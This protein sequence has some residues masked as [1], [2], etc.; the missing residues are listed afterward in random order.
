MS[1]VEKRQQSSE[2][3]SNCRAAHPQKQFIHRESPQVEGLCQC[4]LEMPPHR[5]SLTPLVPVSQRSKGRLEISHLI[6]AVIEQG[7]LGFLAVGTLSDQHIARVVQ[8]IQAATPAAS[9]P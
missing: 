3:V 1:N 7:D 6:K 4:D 2:P 8:T 9:R 5:L